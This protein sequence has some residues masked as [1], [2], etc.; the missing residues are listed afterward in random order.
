MATAHT[1][2]THMI[3]DIQK[4]ISFDRLT[5]DFA[6]TVIVDGARVYLG[7]TPSRM[8]ADSRANAY[9]YEYLTDTHTHESA[10]A[11]LMGG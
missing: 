6:C 2:S 3:A 11:L 8:D 4:E 9:V 10:A 7:N 5:R 1:F